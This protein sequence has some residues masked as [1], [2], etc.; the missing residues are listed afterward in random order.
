MICYFCNQ[1]ITGP[2]EHH[3]PNKA[4]FPDWTEPGHPECHTR[5]HREAGHFVFWGAASAYAGRPGYEKCIEKWPGF[6]R[7]G[8]LAR[9]RSAS[10]DVQGRFT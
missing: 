6:H 4:R 1:E 8:G 5:Y 9:A 2:V 3:H 10:R 7:M